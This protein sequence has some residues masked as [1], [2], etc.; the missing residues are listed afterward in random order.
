MIYG[1]SDTKG[2]EMSITSAMVKE[3]GLNA[4]ATVVGVASADDFTGAPEG[5]RP[6][7]KLQ[8]CR[9]VIVLGAPFPPAALAGSTVEYTSIRNCMVEKMDNAAKDVAARIKREGYGT[10][11]IDGLG[12]RRING[13]FYGHISLKH[14]AE[15]A[16]LGRI[17]RNYLLTSPRYGNLL[18]FS[19]V[20]TEAELSPDRKQG[21]EVCDACDKCVA[22]CP[23]G[24]LDNPALFGQGECYGTCY[25]Q[26][27]GQLELKCF[28]CR[29]VC[30]YRFGDSQGP[31][32]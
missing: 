12:G 17:T 15:L 11:A 1:I 28:R 27:M 7:D 29:T 19:A 22:V 24:A 2:G 9:S 16:G 32:L 4:G 14:S 21:Y 31:E 5:C 23:V 26:V 30:S 10:I 25:K 13:R 18:W 3:L 20:L 6:A 8:G